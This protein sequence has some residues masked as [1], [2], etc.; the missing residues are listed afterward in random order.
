[1]ATLISGLQNAASA[2]ESMRVANEAVI[3]SCMSMAEICK[4]HWEKSVDHAQSCISQRFNRLLYCYK[5]IRVFDEVPD[6]TCEMP[7]ADIDF[8]KL[9]AT[10]WTLRSFCSCAALFTNTLSR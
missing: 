8:T 10:N 1:M 4:T 3:K 5:Q 6:R 9:T 2:H 7:W